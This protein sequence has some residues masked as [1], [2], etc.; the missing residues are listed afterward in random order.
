MAPPPAGTGAA[1]AAAKDPVCGMT[2][3]AGTP[4]RTQ[5]EGETY[6]FCSAGCLA[7]FRA[8]PERY[9]SAPGAVVAT[10]AP[11]LFPPSFR[12]EMGQV[13]VYYEA[14][15]RP[16]PPAREISTSRNESLKEPGQSRLRLSFERRTHGGQQV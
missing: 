4:H 2:V 11:G 12:D 3:Q 5:H 15:P 16:S 13:G 14:P 8:A 1:S 7:K 6:L 10:L 9:L